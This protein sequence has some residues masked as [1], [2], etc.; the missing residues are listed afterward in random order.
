MLS[1]LGRSLCDLAACS[2]PNNPLRP[3][4]ETVL[5]GVESVNVAAGHRRCRVEG[6]N[7]PA[8]AGKSHGHAATSLKVDHSGSLSLGLSLCEGA[9]HMASLRGSR[10][11]CESSI[12]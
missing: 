3:A 8:N 4:F 12:D 2:A 7:I 5:R 9:K 11:H 10:V 6:A 1:L